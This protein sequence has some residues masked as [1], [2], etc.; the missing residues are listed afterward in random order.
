MVKSYSKSEAFNNFGTK[1]S[2]KRWGWSA[3]ADDDT[4]VALAIWK[5]IIHSSGR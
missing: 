2:N 3:I 4:V 5:D 1:Q